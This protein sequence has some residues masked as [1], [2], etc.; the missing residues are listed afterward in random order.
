MMYLAQQWTVHSARWVTIGTYTDYETAW[1]RI[2]HAYETSG[3]SYDD[4]RVHVERVA[5]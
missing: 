5:A 4:F 3:R 1:Q 2:Q